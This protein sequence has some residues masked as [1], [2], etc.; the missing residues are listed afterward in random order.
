M[1]DSVFLMLDWEFL[2]ISVFESPM[3]VSVAGGEVVD[4]V[5]LVLDL[6]DE[7]FCL[8]LDGSPL[9]VISLGDS[10]LRTVL[11]DG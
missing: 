5:T 7:V 4:R 11:V 8:S 2:M 9:G 3:E 1:A 10:M 6:S